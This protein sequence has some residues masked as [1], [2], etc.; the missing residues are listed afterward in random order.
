[1]KTTILETFDLPFR[2]VRQNSDPTYYAVG[3]L[4][5][6]PIQSQT[7][8]YSVALPEGA[9]PPAVSPSF[10]KAVGDGVK[11]YAAE[12]GIVGIR[13]ILTS[14]AGHDVDSSDYSFST[15]AQKAMAKAMEEHGVPVAQ[16]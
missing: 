4:R 7:V 2:W 1:M 9:L 12:H 5:L 16:F 6:E 11:R 13:V 14:I 10:V 3:T 8:E 15:G